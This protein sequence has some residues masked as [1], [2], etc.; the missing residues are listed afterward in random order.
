MRFNCEYKGK[1]HKLLISCPLISK[2]YDLDLMLKDQL[3]KKIEKFF[4]QLLICSK[5]EI[6]LLKLNK[7]GEYIHIL[8]L[9]GCDNVKLNEDYK[10]VEYD[11]QYPYRFYSI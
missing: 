2:K 10:F 8:Y 5:K 9:M 4:Y 11:F 3:L 6:T 1:I 7:I